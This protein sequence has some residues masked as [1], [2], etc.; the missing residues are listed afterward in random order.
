MNY[1]PASS[2]AAIAGRH[3]YTDQNEAI[4]KN[5]ETYN[6]P[7]WK[8]LMAVASE[9]RVSE[10]LVE[11]VLSSYP[12][13]VYD[14]SLS[15][16]EN[17][18]VMS[19]D[20]NVSNII[21]STSIEPLPE[22]NTASV[23]VESAKKAIRETPLLKGLHASAIL[24]P[25]V[26]AVHMSTIVDIPENNIK[27]PKV[28]EAIMSEISKNR[29]TQLESSTI[30]SDL[31]H[32]KIRQLYPD[33]RITITKPSTVYKRYFS[34]CSLSDNRG[35]TSPRDVPRD[36]GSVQYVI[37]GCIDSM[38][39]D[40]ETGDPLCILE[41]KNR[42]RRFFTPEYDMIQLYVYLIL[43][44]IETGYLVQQYSGDIRVSKAVHILDVLGEW[45]V[46]KSEIDS[47]V[48]KSHIITSNKTSTDTINFMKELTF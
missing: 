17:I 8:E 28:K 44:G 35:Y 15:A 4:A 33:K 11:R 45:S 19:L 2:I 6:K 32:D 46:I 36:V 34:T 26:S 39:C 27:D 22:L 42:M 47:A 25:C 24:D 12:E 37:S 23:Y 5:L 43:C 30:T 10:I 29:G 31:L 41:I 21:E 13:T 48:L 16:T 7:V 14:T 18:S 40:S 38:V 3:K 1:M 9:D 20:T